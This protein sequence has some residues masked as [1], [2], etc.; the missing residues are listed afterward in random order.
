MHAI[1]AG[2]TLLVESQTTAARAR[3]VT[4]D[5]LSRIAP[6]DP[7]EVDAALI[8]V[9]ELVAN[10]IQHADGVTGFRLRA[11]PET[12]TISVDDASR[13]RPHTRRSQPWQ[14][15]G[16]GWPLVQRLSKA[17]RVD[18]RPGGKTV[19]SVLSLAH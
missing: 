11:A 16:F 2:D 3:Q 18:V 5:F 8:V 1:E 12:L 9:S 14:P 15:G 7:A 10:A 19:R 6:R 13:E 4:R 17:V